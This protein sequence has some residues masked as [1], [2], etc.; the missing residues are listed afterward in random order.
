M[1]KG[2]EIKKFVA[3]IAPT[4]PKR[5]QPIGGT[6]DVIRMKAALLSLKAWI[7]ESIDA[8]S[9]THLQNR[10]SA[11]CFRI[12]ELKAN[13]VK[14]EQE[15]KVELDYEFLRRSKDIETWLAQWNQLYSKSKKY[16]RV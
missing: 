15:L 5:P 1:S 14:S 16:K 3:P 7:K 10:Q 6:T 13:Y 12:Q 11:K 8:T 9:S 2:R 4:R